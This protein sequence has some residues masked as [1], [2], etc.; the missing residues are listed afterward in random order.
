LNSTGSRA[1]PLFEGL[2]L[3][4]LVLEALPQPWSAI[5][6]LKAH[7]DAASHLVT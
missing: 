6:R 3:A 4:T 7:A 5:A 2:L 1:A